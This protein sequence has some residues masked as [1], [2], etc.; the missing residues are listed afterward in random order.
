MGAEEEQEAWAST[1]LW[2]GDGV[3]GLG[4]S[5]EVGVQGMTCSVV[6]EGVETAVRAGQSGWEE[7]VER[8]RVE[9][10]EHE[11][12]GEVQREQEGEVRCE[13]EGEVQRE[14]EGEVPYG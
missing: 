13:L 1:V 11:R 4:Y 8:G 3:V 12:E 2:A 7:E 6:A 14:R 5:A 10:V 9:E